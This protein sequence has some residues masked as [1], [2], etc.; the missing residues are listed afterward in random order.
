M[1]KFQ[2]GLHSTAGAKNG[3]PLRDIHIAANPLPAW[4]Q[5]VIFEI[6]NTRCGV[7]P[8]EI[9]TNLQEMPSLA[10]SHRCIGDTLKRVKLVNEAAV[11]AN[12]AF[13]EGRA[14]R[15]TLEIEIKT[16]QLLPHL[17]GYLLTHGAGILPGKSHRR[18]N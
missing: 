9:F 3:H 17:T 15:R 11:E 6:E 2:I 13:A 5:H 10:V 8:L 4:E 1:V 14:A 16:I 7:C 18:Q 12:R